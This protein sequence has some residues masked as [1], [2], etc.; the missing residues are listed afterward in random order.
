MANS[1]KVEA[2][3]KGT[4]C[5]WLEDFVPFLECVGGVEKLCISSEKASE[6]LMA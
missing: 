1:L 5:P 4:L 3:A 6:S 2:Q